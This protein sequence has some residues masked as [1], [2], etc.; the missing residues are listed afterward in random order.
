MILEETM[1]QSI[2]SK[3]QIAKQLPFFEQQLKAIETTEPK[4]YNFG[5]KLIERYIMHLYIRRAAFILAIPGLIVSY[6]TKNL[7][8][9]ITMLTVWA[10]AFMLCL[11]TA[12]RINQIRDQYHLDE[13]NLK[14]YHEEKN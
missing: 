6:F 7:L 11:A 2:I 14:S 9:F 3:F 13:T 10:I 1:A 8:P 4:I 5:L 12:T